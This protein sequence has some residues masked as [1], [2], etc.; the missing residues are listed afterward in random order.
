MTAEEGKAG[1]K[2]FQLDPKPLEAI[3]EGE[4]TKLCKECTCKPGEHSSQK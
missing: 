3:I 1:K 4:V 2:S